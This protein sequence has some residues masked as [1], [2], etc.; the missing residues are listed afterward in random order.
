M[1]KNAYVR[2]ISFVTPYF[3]ESYIAIDIRL[4]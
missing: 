3:T 4:F 2:R 1:S